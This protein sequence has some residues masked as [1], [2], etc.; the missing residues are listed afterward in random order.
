MSARLAHALAAYRG[1]AGVGVWVAPRAAGR[2]FGFDQRTVTTQPYLS[3]LAGAR[4][5][6]FAYGTLANEG[7]RRAEW[8]RLGLACD[9]LDCL[10]ALFA[11]RGGYLTRSQAA[12]TAAATA[13]SAGLTAAALL[14]QQGGGR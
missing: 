3:R 12:A 10:A 6:A 9:V 2:L 13:V 7:D 11:G 1:F 14:S 4:E 8:L 5:A